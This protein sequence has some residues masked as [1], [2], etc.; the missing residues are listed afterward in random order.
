MKTSED[1]HMLE[2]EE[3][4]SNAKYL[5]ELIQMD[6]NFGRKETIPARSK[7]ALEAVYSLA[8]VFQKEEDTKI[9][10]EDALSYYEQNGFSSELP[11]SVGL[12]S[13]ICKQSDWEQ[14]FVAITKNDYQIFTVHCAKSGEK[15]LI[16]YLD[17]IDFP[18]WKK[19][20]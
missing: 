7:A 12:Y 3:Y 15:S 6:L 14:I 19:L 4:L 1:E 8:K 2:P 20:A 18:M 5:L 17:N 10:P 13:F 9:E 11:N 16:N